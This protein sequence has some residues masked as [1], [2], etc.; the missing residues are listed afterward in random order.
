MTAAAPVSRREFA[1]KANALLLGLL[2]T[3][4]TRA[5]LIA[6]LS[7]GLGRNYV[8]GWLSERVRD[9]TIVELKTCKPPAYQVATAVI[10]EQP[11]PSMY[12]AW[13]DPRALPLSER[14]HNYIDGKPVNPDASEAR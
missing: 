3:P 14:K 8:Y 10:F 11:A 13:L 1:R 9:G 4:K 12:P 7:G 6:A 2:R 5:G